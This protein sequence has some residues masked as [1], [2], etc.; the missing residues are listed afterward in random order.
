M[1]FKS[2]R[3]RVQLPCRDQTLIDVD[4]MRD[5]AGPMSPP[6]CVVGYATPG[7]CAH[8][9]CFDLPPTG[10]NPSDPQCPAGFLSP[11][12]QCPQGVNTCHGTISLPNCPNSRPPPGCAFFSDC[13]DL[14]D[15]LPCGIDS[16]QQNTG[17]YG[18]ELVYVVGDEGSML[19]DPRALPLLR[20]NLEQRLAEIEA[21]QRIKGDL[22]ARLEEIDRAEQQ[23]RDL[24]DEQ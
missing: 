5:E 10:C 9:S 4:A 16:C 11:D 6:P 17:C 19:A 22:E 8:L 3:L 7:P 23:L 18:S 1:A 2:K 24:D 15:T 12:V 21:A 14:F 20:R 13:P